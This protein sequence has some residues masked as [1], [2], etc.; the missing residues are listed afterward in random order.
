M[1]PRWSA[2]LEARERLLL[3]SADAIERRRSSAHTRV[4]GK[5]RTDVIAL[6]ALDLRHDITFF[7]VADVIDATAN[8]ICTYNMTSPSW[9]DLCS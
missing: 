1:R 7:V 9:D 5:N 2:A 3:S 4:G 6:Q 8:I